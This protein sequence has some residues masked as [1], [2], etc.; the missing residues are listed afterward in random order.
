[1]WFEEY[2]DRAIRDEVHFE[3]ARRYIEDNPVKAGLCRQPSDW[4]FSSAAAGVE[5]R[6]G[7]P[8]SGT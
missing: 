8:R 5:K 4:L 3:T 2:F 1:M 7:R 6:A